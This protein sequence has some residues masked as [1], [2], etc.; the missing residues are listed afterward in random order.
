M[1]ARIA[2]LVREGHL[3]HSAER[4][5]QLESSVIATTLVAER[6]VFAAINVLIANNIWFDPSLWRHLEDIQGFATA[7]KLDQSMNHGVVQ[8]CNPDLPEGDHTSRIGTTKAIHASSGHSDSA[9]FQQRSEVS[10][11]D[12]HQLGQHA[13]ISPT[14]C[15]LVQTLHMLLADRSLKA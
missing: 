13:L 7:F 8:V 4:I 11:D 1:Q 6:A 10:G 14:L 2:E 5:A 3:L 9:Q 12:T 15:S